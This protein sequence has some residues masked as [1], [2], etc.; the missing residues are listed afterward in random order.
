MCEIW[1]DFLQEKDQEPKYFLVSK[2]SLAVGVLCVQSCK[3]FLCAN[4]AAKSWTL[5]LTQPDIILWN[6]KVSSI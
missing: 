1:G 3:A 2:G 4:D 6:F 5:D